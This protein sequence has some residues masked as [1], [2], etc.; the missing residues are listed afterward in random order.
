[1][2]YAAFDRFEIGAGFFFQGQRLLDAVLDGIARKQRHV[3]AQA[4]SG[5]G[6]AVG[7]ACGGRA[8]VVC[9]VQI[10]SKVQRGHGGRLGFFG[11]HLCHFK[12]QAALPNSGVHFF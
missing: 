8:I 7:R 1:M 9:H 2:G 3:E 5:G 12:S 6:G 4:H 11:F 10:A